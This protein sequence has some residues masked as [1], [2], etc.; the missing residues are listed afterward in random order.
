MNSGKKSCGPVVIYT[1][2][3]PQFRLYI[4]GVGS[5]PMEENNF[6]FFFNLLAILIIHWK[7][8]HHKQQLLFYFFFRKFFFFPNVRLDWK[9]IFPIC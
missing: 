2:L 4:V 8:A 6:F 3:P 7:S 1:G 5:I 9:L